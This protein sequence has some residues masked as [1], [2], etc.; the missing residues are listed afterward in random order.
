MQGHLSSL[1]E[2][3]NGFFLSFQDV[4]DLITTY[5]S[6]LLDKNSSD[7][8]TCVNIGFTLSH[9]ENTISVLLHTYHVL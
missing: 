6:S 2:P 7:F 1:E 5:P 8:L 4:T 3:M 9:R